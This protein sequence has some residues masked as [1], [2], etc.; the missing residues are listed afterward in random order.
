MD[1]DKEG[2]LYECGIAESS[3]EAE[4]C[5]KLSSLQ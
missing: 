5:G 2:T 4:F 1:R 3:D